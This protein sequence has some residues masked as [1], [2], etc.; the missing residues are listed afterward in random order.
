MEM[1]W[2]N[3]TEQSGLYYLYLD[4]SISR[5]YL[6]RSR[7]SL[8]RSIRLNEQLFLSKVALESPR[9][10]RMPP[11]RASYISIDTL[12][13]VSHI[14]LLH[15]QRDTLEARHGLRHALQVPKIKEKMVC[16]KLQQSH[17]SPRPVFLDALVAL[18]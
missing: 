9:R 16:G 17:D 3:K 10:I 18:L 2:K 1:A 12:F 7:L 4:Q 11:T 14:L 5:S 8:S 6:Y 13:L 15:A